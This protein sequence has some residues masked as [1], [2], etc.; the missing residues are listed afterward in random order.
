MSLATN[1]KKIA[2]IGGDLRQAHL[3]NMLAE[4]N[5]GCEIFGM[6]MDRPSKD[7]KLSSLVH[8]SNNMANVL[9]ECDVIIFP[10]PLLDFSGAVN[11][12]FSDEHPTFDEFIKL[13]DPAST[14]TAGMV[15]KT[16]HSLAADR[17]VKIY[18]YYLREEF[19][20]MNAVPTAEG[21]LG[22]A[23]AEMRVTLFQSK[24]LVLGYGRIAKVLTRLLQCLGA[25]VRVAARKS[26]D[27]AWA[28]ISGCEAVAMCDLDGSLG[29]VDCV[30]NTVP[31]IILSEEK[32]SRL[33]RR[34]V[35]ID[36]ASNPGG[37]DFEAAKSLELKAV[38]ALSLPG[39]TAPYTAGEI[40]LTTIG[41]ILFERGVLC[42]QES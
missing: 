15:P 35:I 36:L 7:V 39:Q 32:L 14:V 30:F 22:I 6:F 8:V 2:V 33:P 13:I 12:P 25:K 17:G 29:D 9:P 31:A 41:N 23:M 38:R 5:G 10:L 24:C 1:G 26:S 11:T 27:L 19:A 3:S 37:V 20:V 21:A 16:A 40:I 28:R 42:G 34:C 18:D 4:K